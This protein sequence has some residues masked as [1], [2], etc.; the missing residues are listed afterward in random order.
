MNQLILGAISMAC[1]V[2]ALFFLRF[3]KN[4]RDR[5]FLFFATAFGL[6]GINRAL[7]GL[8]Q[9]SN[10]NEPLFYLIRFV[11]YILILV[12]IL[13]KNRGQRTASNDA[14]VENERR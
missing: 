5:F 7:L 4:T 3:W 13:D 10:E 9:G 8:D 11:S 14:G 6:E 1:L 12:A 2:I